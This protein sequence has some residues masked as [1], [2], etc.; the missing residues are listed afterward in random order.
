LFLNF[1][2]SASTD[3]AVLLLF[4]AKHLALE[5]LNLPIVSHAGFAIDCLFVMKELSLSLGV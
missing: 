1:A 2:V 4:P 5:N 3:E